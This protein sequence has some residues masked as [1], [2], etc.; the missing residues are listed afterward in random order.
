ME[1]IK[2]L[3][4]EAINRLD[5]YNG[6]SDC[7]CQSQCRITSCKTMG[8]IQQALALLTEKPPT[9]PVDAKTPTNPTVGS[10][11]CPKC[12]GNLRCDLED[13]YDECIKCGWSE[14][15]TTHSPSTKTP[16]EPAV[17]KPQN[18]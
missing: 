1:K 17:D 18:S 7:L 5:C 15:A 14:W 11:K 2:E 10:P 3:L 13:G 8:L 6:S 12:G 4:E 16:A 9:M